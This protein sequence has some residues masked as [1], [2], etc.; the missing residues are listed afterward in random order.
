MLIH[1]EKDKTQSNLVELQG[2]IEKVTSE[3][4]HTNVFEAY[5]KMIRRLSVKGIVEFCR[6]GWIS[7]PYAFS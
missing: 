2:A 1:Y 7:I 4:K 3:F 6:Q 5:P